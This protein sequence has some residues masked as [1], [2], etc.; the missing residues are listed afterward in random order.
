LLS[1]RRNL[2]GRT[3]NSI[4]ASAGKARPASINPQSAAPGMFDKVVCASGDEGKILIA[5]NLCKIAF[6]VEIECSDISDIGRPMS[7]RSAL[8]CHEIAL[9]LPLYLFG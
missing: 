1:V 9:S 2:S 5:D 6:S 3:L 4:P 8:M 7:D